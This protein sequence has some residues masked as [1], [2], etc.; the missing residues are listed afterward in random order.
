MA[1][2]QVQQ[3]FQ[4]FA[5][6]P[7]ADPTQTLEQM[8]ANLDGLAGM[9]PPLPG[10]SIERVADRPRRTQWTRPEGADSDRVVLFM[11]GGGYMVG[12]VDSY[13]DLT[14]RLALAANAA[15]L[16]FDYRLAPENPFPAALE[17]A[18]D[19]YRWLVS[20]GHEPSKISFVGDSA[21]G[22]LCLATAIALRDA[23]DVQGPGA[24]AVISP[25]VDLLFESPSLVTVDD[26]LFQLGPVRIMAMSYL[27][28]Q[29]P[30]NPLISPL[31]AD[32]GK[33]PPTLVQVGGAEGLRDDGVRFTERAS[34]V[35]ADVTLEVWDDMFHA[36][37]IWAAMLDDGQRAIERIGEFVRAR[38]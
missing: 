8:R 32:L 6:S 14:G 12:S 24:I 23:G 36:W 11:H 26:P 1:N 25:W 3:I 4:L 33:L 22:G 5:S 20:S 21:G 13:R 7:L 2:A 19:T 28:G 35:G 34:E 27:Q 17:D 18:L 38:T 37:P 15:V 31:Y 30:R 10:I 29:D 9:F 16:S